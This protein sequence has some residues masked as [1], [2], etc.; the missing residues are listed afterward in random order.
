MSTTDHSAAAPPH[1][2]QRLFWSTAHHFRLL[3]V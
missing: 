1:G 3:V 2:R